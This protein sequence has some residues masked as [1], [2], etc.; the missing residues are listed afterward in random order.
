MCAETVQEEVDDENILLG[1]G[2]KFSY[3]IIEETEMVGTIVI[4][5]NCLH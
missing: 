2:T 5:I 3:F 1:R 4:I